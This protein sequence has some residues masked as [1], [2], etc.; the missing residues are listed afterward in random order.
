MLPRS[1]E[2]VLRAAG[3]CVAAIVAACAT[4][5]EERRSA[6]RYQTKLVVRQEIVLVH[7]PAEVLERHPQSPQTRYYLFAPDG[8][9]CEVDFVQYS[10]VKP[11]DLVICDWQAAPRVRATR[12]A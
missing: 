2:R 8:M 4:T 1:P 9:V 12:P 3:L 11:D 7:A 10:A 5:L 6:S